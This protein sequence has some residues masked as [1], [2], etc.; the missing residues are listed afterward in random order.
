MRTR[1]LLTAPPRAVPVQPGALAPRAPTALLP[2]A[3][4]ST[5]LPE[6]SR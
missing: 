3:A 4:P 2:G 1:I 6:V 5:W